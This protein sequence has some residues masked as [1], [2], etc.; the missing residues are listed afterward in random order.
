MLWQ[1]FSRNSRLCDA[2][3]QTSA[4]GGGEKL[5]ISA[6]EGCQVIV[7]SKQSAHKLVT[8]E[9]QKKV[10]FVMMSLNGKE[11]AGKGGRAKI[12]LCQKF[13]VQFV[14]LHSPPCNPKFC[15]YSFLFI[16]MSNGCHSD[17]LC[18]PYCVHHC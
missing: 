17:T 10:V 3:L 9:L 6:P 8:F 2:M 16:L 15:S 13:M 5:P 12:F 14:L 4:L 11:R 18:L 1:K 7:K